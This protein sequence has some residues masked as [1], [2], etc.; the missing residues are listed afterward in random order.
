MYYRFSY[1]NSSNVTGL[2]KARLSY[3]Y[4]PSAITVCNSVLR[5]YIDGP[6]KYADLLCYAGVESREKGNR[7][8]KGNRRV[9]G[10]R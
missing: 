3:R 5:E 10:D 9:R 6:I 2:L 8:H 1:S 7:R 4:L